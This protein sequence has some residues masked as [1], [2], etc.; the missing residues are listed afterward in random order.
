MNTARRE[1]VLHITVQP[2]SVRGIPRPEAPS[3]TWTSRAR[4]AP[5]AAA[6][7]AQNI[8]DAV[9]DRHDDRDDCADDCLKNHGDC[10]DDSIDAASDG[11]N[12]GTHYEMRM[13]VTWEGLGDS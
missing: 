12:D 3:T 5:A 13:F 2:H 11:R 7:T 8:K 9:E 4:M 10:A 6:A 1:P